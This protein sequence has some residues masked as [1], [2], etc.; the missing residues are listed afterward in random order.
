MAISKILFV[1]NIGKLF[2]KVTS[3]VQVRKKIIYIL[4]VTIKSCLKLKIATKR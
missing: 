3:I 4:G 1:W 2:H